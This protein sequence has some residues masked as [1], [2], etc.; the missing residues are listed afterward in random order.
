MAKAEKEDVKG[1]YGHNGC[2]DD[3]NSSNGHNDSKNQ[4]QYDISGHNMCNGHIG[5]YEHI[6]VMTIHSLVALL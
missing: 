6:V 1:C 2:H 5:C 4:C 3:N